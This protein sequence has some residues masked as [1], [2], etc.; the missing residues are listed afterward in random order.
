MTPKAHVIFNICA[1]CIWVALGVPTIL[2][3]REN[4]FWIVVMSWYAIVVGHIGALMTAMAEKK[5]DE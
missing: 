5:A 3:W 1:L 2:W 4:V